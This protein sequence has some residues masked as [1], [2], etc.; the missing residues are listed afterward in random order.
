MQAGG[1]GLHQ[2]MKVGIALRVLGEEIEKLPL[3][4]ERDELAARR[5]V[6][7]IGQT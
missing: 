3:R 1:L 6:G 4:H 7:E 5:Q 2:Q